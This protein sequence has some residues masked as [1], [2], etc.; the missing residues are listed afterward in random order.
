MVGGKQLT[1]CWQVD[2]LK[3]SCGNKDDTVAR[4][5]IWKNARFMWEETQLHENVDILLNTGELL[6]LQMGFSFPFLRFNNLRTYLL[7]MRTHSLSYVGLFLNIIAN[8][9]NNN[10]QHVRSGKKVCISQNPH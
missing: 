8:A 6:K 10:D 4:V 5:R 7:I 2:D 1:V 3:I 9:V